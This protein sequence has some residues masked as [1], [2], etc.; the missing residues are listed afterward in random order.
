MA[1]STRSKDKHIGGVQIPLFDTPSEWTPPTEFPDLSYAKYVG[2][3]CE[4]KDPNLVKQGPGFLRGEAK[5]VGVS[6]ATE[7]GFK[8][9]LPFDHAV[10][11]Q[12][13]RDKVV[14]YVRTQVSRDNQVKVGANVMYDIEALDSLGIQI[15]GP[16]HD[17]QVAGPLLDEEKVDGFSLEQLS[18]DYLGVGKTEGLL[19]EAANNWGLDKKRQLW[20]LDPK[21]VGPYAE[22]DALNP[23][24]ILQKQLVELEKQRLLPVWDLECDLTPVLWKMRKRGVRVDLDGAAQ[25]ASEIAAEEQELLHSIRLSFS[26]ARPGFDP[27]D[28]KQMYALLKEEG[29]E[30]HVPFT[31]PTANFPHGQPSIT[32]EWLKQ[33]SH[34]HPGLQHS[35]EY[36]NMNKMRRDFV[37]GLVIN[38]S[39]RG[40]LHPQWHQLK[41][42]DEDRENG[43]KTGRVASSKPNLTQIPSRHPRW[44]KKVRALFVADE[45]GKW[46]KH[47]FSQQEPRIALHFAYLKRYE[48]AAEARQKYLDDPTTDYHDMTKDLIF[49]RSGIVVERRVAKD[50]NLGS[51]YGMGKFK[52][53]AKLG[54][55]I[56]AAGEILEIHRK[57]VPFLKKLEERCMELVH[58]QGYIRTMSGRKRRF[59]SWEAEDW[60]KRSFPIRDY[61]EAVQIYGKVVRAFAHKA[62]NAM[63]QGTAADQTKRAIIM[64]DAEGLTPQI[65]VYDELNQTI[66]DDRAAWRIKEV[67]ENALP[68]LTVPHLANPDVGTSWGTVD[69]KWASRHAP[70]GVIV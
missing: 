11:N 32:N 23:V 38:R 34:I 58:A 4:T 49:E 65:Q 68:D 52:L 55:D 51:A 53:A 67:M 40:R 59:D 25:L 5:V 31:K 8:I 61:H 20:M 18:L 3:D 54:L 19:E 36:R 14:D 44:G 57:G 70:A 7:T 10:G 46:C 39:I 62:L 45:G 69:E 43:T 6:L 29:L 48:G 17:I 28:T 42:D 16:V 63:V 56:D 1:R 50:I 64:L 66:Y 47:D 37:E 24:L 22:D 2:F 21:Y 12:L 33:Y 35:L 13:P 9:Y 60:K 30:S 15:R 41:A 27:W 26:S